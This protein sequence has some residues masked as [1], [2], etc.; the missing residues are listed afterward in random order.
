[1]TDP[2]SHPD[3]IQAWIDETEAFDRVLSIALSLEKP[4]PASWVSEEAHVAENTARK[5]LE[6]LESLEIVTAVERGATTYYPNSAYLRF[7]EVS[8]LAESYDKEELSE[9][10]GRLKEKDEETSEEYDAAGPEELR[11]LITDEATQSAEIREYRKVASEWETLRH[12]LAIT[13]QALD[14]YAQHNP[15]HQPQ[16]V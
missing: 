6:R 15:G 3:G 11:E 14:Q 8:S 12:R 16:A 5:N 9:K 13:E 1:M 4:R 10:L 2:P 7:R